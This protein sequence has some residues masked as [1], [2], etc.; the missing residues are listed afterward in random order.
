[1]SYKFDIDRF[2]C[3]KSFLMLEDLMGKEYGI[4]RCPEF[5]Y[6]A[7]GKPF[8][9]DFPHI[10]FNLSHCRRG[11]AC[12]VSNHPVGIDIEEIQYDDLLAQRVLNSNEYMETK[13]STNPSEKFIEFWTKKESC[14]KLTG[15][16]LVDDVKDLLNES[17]GIVFQSVL[18]RERGYVW[19]L[20][21]C[22]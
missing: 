21:S 7:N 15:Q 3:A 19:S 2:L 20:A 22:L 16:G 9:S 14:L 18:N 5:S 4:C 1:M 10:H 8:F 6:G 11:I 12:V 13:S 17:E